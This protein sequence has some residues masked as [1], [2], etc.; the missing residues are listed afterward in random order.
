MQL[1]SSNIIILSYH[2]NFYTSNESNS[3]QYFTQV[4][5]IENLNYSKS[6]KQYFRDNA[7]LYSVAVDCE[8]RNTSISDNKF[9][10]CF[11]FAQFHDSNSMLVAKIKFTELIYIEDYVHEI[12]KS[13]YHDLENKTVILEINNE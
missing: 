5:D 1:T 13:W 2:S 11:T 12:F 7:D 10:V 9:K 4:A 6:L 3:N 8:V